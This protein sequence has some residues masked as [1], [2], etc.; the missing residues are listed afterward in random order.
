MVAADHGERG[1]ARIQRLDDALA[2]HRVLADQLELL[3]G[4]GSRLQQHSIGDADLPEVVERAV[5]AQG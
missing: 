4:E 1:W 5:G 2:D 3:L